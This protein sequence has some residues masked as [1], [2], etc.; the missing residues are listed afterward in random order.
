MHPPMQDR[1]AVAHARAVI[2]D[3]LI[4]PDQATA[5][6]LRHAE[7]GLSNR[8]ATLV[9]RY[10]NVRSRLF[11]HGKRSI[12]AKDAV[13]GPQFDHFWNSKAS[14]NALAQEF[15]EL[16]AVRDDAN[17]Q[18]EKR[19]KVVSAIERKHAELISTAIEMKESMGT[20]DQ[21]TNQMEEELGIAR[22]LWTGI[23]GAKWLAIKLKMALAMTRIRATSLRLI[24]FSLALLVALVI[25]WFTPFAESVL[26]SIPASNRHYAA[27]SILFISQAILFDPV[28][29]RIKRAFSWRVHAYLTRRAEEL[30]ARI[31]LYEAQMAQSES[32]LTELESRLL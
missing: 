17:T 2:G 27:V 28:F 23:Q 10:E 3:R 25:D 30:L 9:Q 1:D 22:Q 16:C 14:A 11:L 31:E 13:V 20:I 18:P 8:A 15:D 29:S 32:A 5:I 4:D 26:A 19:R 21:A 7:R 24:F 6:L 12:T